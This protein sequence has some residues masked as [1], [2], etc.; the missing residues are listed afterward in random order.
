MLENRTGRAEQSTTS[1]AIEFEAFVVL[2]AS[3]STGATATAVATTTS[4]IRCNGL[5]KM[6]S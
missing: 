1:R 4:N 6:L 5:E 3:L 2:C